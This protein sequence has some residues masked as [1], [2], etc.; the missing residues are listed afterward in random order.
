MVVHAGLLGLLRRVVTRDARDRSGHAVRH[1]AARVAGS[2]A[3]HGRTGDQHGRARRPLLQR[4]LP[5]AVAAV[6]PRGG[7][8][9]GR[10]GVG[11]ARC[12][13]CPLCRAL[14]RERAADP[15]DRGGGLPRAGAGAWV[16]GDAGALAVGWWGVARDRHAMVALRGDRL[17]RDHAGHAVDLVAGE[18]RVDAAAA[19]SG[20]ASAGGVASSSRGCWLQRR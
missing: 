9:G 15:G 18:S 1:R 2:A 7:G 12:I 4:L 17:G 5:G 13:A 11:P 20:G 16:D 6:C 10:L 8:R 3:G 14:L 19:G